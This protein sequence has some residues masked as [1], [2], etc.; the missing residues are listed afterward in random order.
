MI[1]CHLTFVYHKNS[2]IDARQLIYLSRFSYFATLLK[3]SC[4]PRT[5][6][7]LTRG[8]GGGGVGKAYS[9]SDHQKLYNISVFKSVCKIFFG[10]LMSHLLHFCIVFC[11]PKS[12]WP[13]Q[14]TA[15]TSVPKLLFLPGFCSMG[16]HALC[17][18]IYNHCP[19]LRGQ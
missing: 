9:G 8:E 19:V 11:I 4:L 2:Y 5:T 1:N 13:L 7:V 6:L 16:T 14:W 12:T 10:F 15:N 18:P 17:T 3:I